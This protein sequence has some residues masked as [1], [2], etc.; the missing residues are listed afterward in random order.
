MAVY[1]VVEYQ[2]GDASSKLVVAKTKVAPLATISIPR[3]ELMAA[4]LSLHLA[5]TVAEVYK[6]D[7]MNV[8]Y[9]TDS[10]NVLWWVRNHSRKFKP[11]VANRISQIQRLSTPEKWNHVRTKE[12]P[13]DLL[14]RRMLIEDLAMSDLWWYGPEN[15]R[16][17]NE[18]LIK[19][20]IERSP[21]V[22]EEKVIQVVMMANAT[23]SETPSL[24]RLNPKHH[25][26]WKKLIRICGW[27]IRFITNVRRSVDE[28]IV[29]E[30]LP[31][32][33]K[34]AEDWFIRSAQEESFTEEYRL[35][36]KGKG[37]S[38][39]SKLICLQPAMGEYGT[40][41]CNSRIVNAEFLP[42][43]T[44]YPVILPRTSW[45]TKLIIK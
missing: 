43:E 31:S 9:W 5:N 8:N 4:V 22:Q 32:E 16:N 35:L 27:V 33:V 40:M 18:A 19:T 2:N 13:T 15:L 36:K 11:F 1:L 45:V 26:S 10:M 25:S 6:I 38:S 29:G 12:N 24:W 30:L 28:K 17:G 14:S 3:L 41:R 20:D 39:S 37:I 44:R 42:I 34:D 21:E 23:Q 7:Q